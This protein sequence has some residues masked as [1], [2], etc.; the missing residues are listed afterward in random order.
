MTLDPQGTLPVTLEITLAPP[1]LRHAVHILP[2]QLGVWGRQVREILCVIDLRPVP[3]RPDRLWEQRG[4]E[5]LDVV[6]TCCSRFSHARRAT[7]DYGS[8]TSSAVSSMFFRGRPV[9]AKTAR[10]GPFYAYFFGLHKDQFDYILHLDSDMLFGGGSQT[11][12][13]EAVCL[14]R[15]RPDVLV[16]QPL[17]GPP[18]ADGGVHAEG[19]KQERYA[20]PAFRFETF[21]TRYFLLDRNR[22][23]DRIGGLE[24]RQHAPLRRRVGLAEWVRGLPN[25]S[26]RDRLRPLT[27]STPPY[28]LPE[29]L[30]GEAMN[31][32]GL[33][34]ID[35]LGNE[36]G[37]WSLHPR[38]RPERYY[39]VLPA[40]IQRIESGDIS[41]RQRGH[42]DLDE[43]MLAP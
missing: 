27:L 39:E 6:D 11:W 21:T 8:R 13:R 26:F 20:Y 28:E 31:R 3:G 40:L 34:R 41:D 16:T 36:P 24:V 19:A 22:F 33:Y 4:R 14:L 37:M 1:D 23:L 5:L 29:R 15:E 38:E 25:L 12:V 7:V 30:L 18:T 10:G 35:F 9:P 42:Y 17:P 43:S 2:H 32:A